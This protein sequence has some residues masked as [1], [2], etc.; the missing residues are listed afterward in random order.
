MHPLTKWRQDHPQGYM[1]LR[2]FSALIAV[3][4]AE[5]CR[6]E[7]GMRRMPAER[8]TIISALTGIPKHELRPDIF[9][10]PETEV[11]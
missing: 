8:V 10:P 11:A 6:W 9:E 7:Q 5:I 3:S 1:S 2:K 4:E